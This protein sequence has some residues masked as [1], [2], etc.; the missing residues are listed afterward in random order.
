[1]SGSSFVRLVCERKA[2]RKGL[3]RILPAKLFC[4]TI[5]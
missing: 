5:P 3:P 1:M 4:G 2:A